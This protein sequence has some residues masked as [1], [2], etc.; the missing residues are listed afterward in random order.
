[1]SPSVRS[2]QSSATAPRTSI[3][4]GR[5]RQELAPTVPVGSMTSRIALVLHVWGPAERLKTREPANS[6]LFLLRETKGA[7]QH[8]ATELLVCS[9]PDRWASLDGEGLHL[10]QE[11]D[12][13]LIGNPSALHRLA[14]VV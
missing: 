1:M 14:Q 7:R 9:E 13:R 4:P 12:V 10:F 8:L 6:G 3:E 2:Q 11:V 5:A